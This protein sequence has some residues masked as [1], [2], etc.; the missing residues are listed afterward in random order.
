LE[1]KENQ[2]D[3]KQ[4]QKYCIITE[5][6]IYDFFIS[7]VL[8]LFYH[9]ITRKMDTTCFVLDTLI[10]ESCRKF[11]LSKFNINEQ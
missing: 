5:Q 11:A 3:K 8:S 7:A 6:L 9:S 2:A 10:N 1:T 4:L